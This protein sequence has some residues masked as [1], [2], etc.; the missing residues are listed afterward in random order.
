MK[1]KTIIAIAVLVVVGIGLVTY[2]NSKSP[3]SSFEPQVCEWETLAMQ[4]DTVA[5]HRLI[6]FYDSA[7]VEYVE[8]VE[9][10]DAWGNEIELDNSDQPDE[11]D[12]EL[13][14]A[15]HK[16]LNYWLDRG[17][18]NNDPVAIKTMG[19]RLYYGDE[20]ASIA[21][22]SQAADAGDATAALFCGSA[23]LNQKRGD[24]AIKYL[25]M[26]YESGVPSA[27]WHLAMCYAQGVGT[28]RNRMKAVEVMRHA[29]LLDYPEAVSEMQR[30]EPDNEMWQHKAD[31]LDIQFPNLQ[32]IPD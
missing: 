25:T 11:C 18:A 26:A 16:R 23:C 12:I 6:E 21:Y 9:A 4:G 32:V 2:A 31:S 27:G 19:M 22:L 7:A 5:M 28:G 1:K 8:V 24:E 10:V 15:Y 17:I 20:S 29:A 3:V 14:E 30:I 13:S